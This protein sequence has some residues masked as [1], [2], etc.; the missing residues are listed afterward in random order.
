M[1]RAYTTEDY[2]GVKKREAGPFP[3]ARVQ[4]ETSPLGQAET[5]TAREQCMQT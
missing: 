5:D 2:A 3:A 1:W 4:S